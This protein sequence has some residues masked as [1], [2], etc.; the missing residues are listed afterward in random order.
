MQHIYLLHGT[1]KIRIQEWVDQYIAKHLPEGK[2]DLNYSVFDMDEVPVQHVIQQAETVPFLR[3]CRVILVNSAEF[4]G[5]ANSKQDHDLELLARFIAD[6]PEYSHVIFTTKTEKLDKRK[7]VTKLL[8]QQKAVISC[9]A[10]QGRELEIWTRERIKGNGCKIEDHALEQLL[11]ATNGNLTTL[12]TEIDKLCL[13]V[14]QGNI[15]IQEVDL[16]VSRTLEQNLF[17]FIDFVA[18]MRIPEGMQMI[19]DLLKSKE[20]P[21]LILFLLTKRFRTM[22]V[23]KELA[24]KG[25][26]PQQIAGQIGQHPYTIKLTLDQSKNFSVQRLRKILISLAMADEQIKT[27]Q[28]PET[29]ALEKFVLSLPE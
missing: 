23:G 24:G 3:D 26:S 4:F 13:Y 6:P 5:T 10:I 28:L 18:Q 11:H 27:G 14:N 25:Y 15:T 8:E 2:E 12:A 19:Y 21:I 29:L 1:E 7:K 9:N 17:R 20:S 22:L 16:L